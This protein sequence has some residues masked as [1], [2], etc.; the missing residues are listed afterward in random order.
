MAKVEIDKVV[1]DFT[2][3]ASSGQ[4]VS[5]QQYR[6]KRLVIYFYPADMTPSCTQEACDFRDYNGQ[7]A[8]LNAEVIGISP[9][10]LKKHDKFITKCELP[11]LLLSDPDH[12]VCEL[13][14]IWQLKK[15]YGKEYMGVVRSTFLIDENGKLVKEWRKVRVKNHVAEV[16]QALKEM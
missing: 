5:L 6:G 13:F 15:L 16:L 8:Q 9:D 7:F 12:Q 1:P 2:L 14:G 11:F 4:E 10:D 3:L